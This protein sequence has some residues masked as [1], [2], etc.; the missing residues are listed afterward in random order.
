MILEQIQQVWSKPHSI[1][2]SGIS[3]EVMLGIEFVANHVKIQDYKEQLL[4]D[5]HFETYL[6]ITTDF[7]GKMRAVVH[8]NL[9]SFLNYWMKNKHTKQF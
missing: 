4:Q 6:S 3:C 8:I 5:K 7:H 1:K 9:V 2:L